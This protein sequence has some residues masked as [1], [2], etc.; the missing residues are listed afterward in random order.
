MPVPRRLA[1]WKNGFRQSIQLRLTFYFIVILLPLVF[2]GIFANHRSQS[3]MENQ[4][5]HRTRASMDS[6]LSSIELLMKNVE[7]L[8]AILA[9]DPLLLEATEPVE[10]TPS[11]Q[12]YLK[13]SELIAQFKV[14][15]A[16]NPIVSQIS[17][18]HVP[19]RMWVST[20]FGG[21]RVSDFEAR[22]WYREAVRGKGGSVVLQASDPLFPEIPSLSDG[23]DGWLMMRMLR[24]DREV[25]EAA[26]LMLHLDIGA[27]RSMMLKLQ[28]S[29]RSRL[30]LLD[31]QGRMIAGSVSPEANAAAAGPVKVI[32]SVSA[33]YGWRLTFTQPREEIERELR[34]LGAYTYFIAIVSVLIAGW[35]SWV[36]YHSIASPLKTL[37]Q[38]LNRVGMGKY[39]T[40]LQSD[41]DDEIGNIIS[42]FN[43][44]ATNQKELLH[45]LSERKLQLTKA[46]LKLLQSQ[47][48]PHFLYN[49][50][51]CI[52]WMAK[53]YDAD[54][55][56]EM[57]VSLS[58][59]FRLSL[60][61]GKELFTVRE[62]VE[63]LGYYIR[64][65][66]IRYSN[67]FAV[68]YDIDEN[69]LDV[70]VLKLILQPIVE[71]A[72]I[73]GLERSPGKGRLEIS[74]RLGE[75]GLTLRVEDTGA[76]LGADR[77]AYIRAELGR[78]PSAG[79]VRDPEQAAVPGELFGLINTKMRLL[80]YYGAGADLRLDSVP[81]QG[82]TVTIVCP[83]QPGREDGGEE[84]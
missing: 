64:I 11:P 73:H 13:L 48:N 61:K 60:G 29:E 53:N 77:L 52:H 7:E 67:K 70:P 71:N 1:D 56:S 8:S 34:T 35:I 82:T 16:V 44:M 83:L 4:I 69:T 3:I 37:N 43:R 10:R 84:R 63:H 78:I 6:V 18:L 80:L 38:G 31:G 45:E 58:R 28:P 26:V 62:T 20:R 46:E 40:Q 79:S 15:T 59:F 47:T 50:L 27:V 24:P 41:R 33:L 23:A 32:E 49:T 5:E 12:T 30:A 36:V 55:I 19:T 25:E 75:D 54:D 17:L 68:Q 57:V 21:T 22:D 2:I 76:G 42:S 74:S 66:Q 14:I 9:V 81:E 65:Q 39:D 51:D 72:I